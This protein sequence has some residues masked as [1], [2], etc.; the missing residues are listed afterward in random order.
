[1]RYSPGQQAPCCA[2]AD[3]PVRLGRRFLIK[4]RSMAGSVGSL[5]PGISPNILH[6]CSA[7]VAVA[8]GGAVSD[9]L[10]LQCGLDVVVKRGR[11]LEGGGDDLARGQPPGRLRH[12]SDLVF[13]S[14]PLPAPALCSSA[15]RAPMTRWPPTP[16]PATAPGPG[17]CDRCLA[18]AGPE[19]S[20]GHHGTFPAGP[21]RPA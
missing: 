13:G 7:I 12:V 18:Q 5:W 9:R 3:P 15:G 20:L 16:L 14:R 4:I 17:I 6:F 19:P 11:D 2:S 10:L 21:S 8:G 1:M